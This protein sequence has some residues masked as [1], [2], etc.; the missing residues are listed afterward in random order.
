MVDAPV[1]SKML[2]GAEPDAECQDDECLLIL[3]QK[4]SAQ[5]LKEDDNRSMK[6]KA[7]N[8]I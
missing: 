3:R 2:F 7:D 6:K 1:F 8:K 4:N 5:R